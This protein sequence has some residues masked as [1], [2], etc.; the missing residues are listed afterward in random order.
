M[1][2]VKYN[3]DRNERWREIKMNAVNDWDNIED[4]ELI[5]DFITYRELYEGNSETNMSLIRERMRDFNQGI[6]VYIEDKI[7]LDWSLVTDKEKKTLSDPDQIDLIIERQL[8]I[9]KGFFKIQTAN[10]WMEEAKSTPIP[11]MLFSEL[12][13]EN[14]VCIMFA[15][16]N[17]GKS[18]LAVQIGNSISKGKPINGFKMEAIKQPVLYFDFELSAKQFET[19]YSIKNETKMEFEEHY[20]FDDNFRRVEIDPDA[21]IPESM[22]FENYL[23]QCIEDSMKETDSKILIIDNIT[24]LKDGTEKASE[25]SPLMRRLKD[26]KNKNGLSILVLA[27]TP[28]RDSSR[29]LSLNDL[30]GSKM[31]SNFI[32]SCFAIGVSHKDPEF[33]Y[34]KQLKARNTSYVYG[35]DNVAVCQLHKPSNFLKFS[36]VSEESELEHLKQVSSEDKEYRVTQAMELKKQGASNVKIASELGVS[37][38]AVRKWLK[39][40]SNN[41]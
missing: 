30:A 5:W 9:N 26:L 28:K 35:E 10:Q 15:D 22:K 21:E 19:R 24:F 34:I 6:D 3:K 17:V 39:K 14:E 27:H 13:H 31:L 41:S 8:I 1:E 33:R 4:R 40:H 36:Y 32:D 29:P 18:I 25:A 16:T 7:D 11:L 23:I 20:L 38:G 12:W 37:E 2:G